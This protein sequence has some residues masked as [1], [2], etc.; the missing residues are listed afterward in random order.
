MA[1]EAQQLPVAAIRRIVIVV[2]ILVMDGELLQ[3]GAGKRPR[4]FPA[5]PRVNFE[6]LFPISLVALLCVAPGIGNDP[7]ELAGVGF[8]G[9]VAT[10]MKKMPG[11]S[12]KNLWW[13]KSDQSETQYIRLVVFLSSLWGVRVRLRGMVSWV[14]FPKWLSNSALFKKLGMRPS[15]NK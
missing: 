15:T 11:K 8:L 4:A 1:V 14:R 9:H 12:A 7:V 13:R 10:L 5:N 2:V 3:V 6:R